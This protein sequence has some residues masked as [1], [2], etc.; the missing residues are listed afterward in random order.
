MKIFGKAWP[1][2]PYKSLIII[3]AGAIGT[4]FAHAFSSFGTKVS[5]VQERLLPKMDRDI[6]KYLGERFA[7]FGIDVYYNQISK[8]I[9]QKDGEKILSIEDKLTGEIRE[10]KAE[11]ILVAA[12]VIPNTDLLELSNTS[13]QRNAQGWIRTNEFL[14][15][16]LRESMR[17]EI[18]MVTDSY[19]IR[20]TMRRIF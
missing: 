7:D 14:E 6:S 17:L 19:D 1:L 20:Q 16:S 9:S 4:E 11:E 13:I 12:G 18:L 5:V 15:T 3:G 8:K 10:L 2:K